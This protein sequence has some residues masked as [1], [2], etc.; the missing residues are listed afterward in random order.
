M[1]ECYYCGV[2]LEWSVQGVHPSKN[3]KQGN[4]EHIFP[5]CLGGE[6]VPK[7][8]N[9]VW[10]CNECNHRKSGKHPL[11]WFLENE[12][13]GWKK[14]KQKEYL[15]RIK[16]AVLIVGGFQKYQGWAALDN[17]IPKFVKEIKFR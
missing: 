9:V 8:I 7:E 11:K 2:E 12:G 5:I 1:T 16:V 6:I 3:K 4:E 17:H 13:F 10:S 14:T 15:Y